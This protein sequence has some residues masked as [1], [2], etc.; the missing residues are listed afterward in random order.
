MC[1]F[2]NHLLVYSGIFTKGSWTKTNCGLK[3]IAVFVP[4]SQ[5]LY[6]LSL[7]CDLLVAVGFSYIRQHLVKN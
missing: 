5:N 2:I 4:T 1:K 7:E 6:R 3:H